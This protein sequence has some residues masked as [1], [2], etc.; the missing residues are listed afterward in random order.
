MAPQ[1]TRVQQV[2]I[3]LVMLASIGMYY[4]VAKAVPPTSPQDDPMIERILLAMAVVL[5]GASFVIK[6]RVSVGASP[7]A[8]LIIALAFC[9]AAA[10]LGLVVWFVTG[11]QYYYVFFV[12]GAA[13]QVM[14]YPGANE[15]V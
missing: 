14:H 2:I 13:G 8:R 7:S 5:V 15:E 4:A 3:W 1:P 10:V 9:E 6:S 12:L 11:W